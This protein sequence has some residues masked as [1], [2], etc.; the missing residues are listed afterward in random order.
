[1]V[2]EAAKP[3]A[4]E[5]R[6]P[7]Y[8]A[9]GVGGT[10]T[11]MAALMLRWCARGTM[12]SLV[13]VR[14]F[15]FVIMSAG[16]ATG[17]SLSGFTQAAAGSSA[18]SVRAVPGTAALLSGLACV[19]TRQCIGVGYSAGGGAVVRI[20]AGIPSAALD[21]GRR[22]D[23]LAAASCSSAG[24]CEAVGEAHSEGGVVVADTGGT[25]G[26][27]HRLSGDVS[28]LDGV[29]CP[30]GAHCVAV[31]AN[32]GLVVAITRGAPTSVLAAAKVGLFNGIACISTS[33][34]E[35]VGTTPSRG[36]A[37][38]IVNGMPT[39]REPAAPDSMDPVSIACPGDDGGKCVVVGGYFIP[40]PHQGTVDTLGSHGFGPVH[41]VAGAAF[42][43]SV[44]CPT[45]GTC[46]ALGNT[47]STPEQGLLVQIVNG[48]PQPPR[49][50]PDVFTTIVCPD[51]RVCYAVGSDPNP[52]TTDSSRPFV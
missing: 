22:G 46:F 37:V 2:A 51:T 11:G 43:S 3:G 23:T 52:P 32:E 21:V 27:V 5:S 29:A 47:A 41:N 39:S 4:H 50:L 35:G 20:S 36:F 17:L 9:A 10:G 26:G 31:G 7:P 30:D 19:N 15:S 40:H 44:S 16:L 48:V 38:R 14:R 25:P 6:C 8:R 49:E 28:A 24:S 45:S 1:M 12:P 33:V 13:F 18:V 34:C 42:L